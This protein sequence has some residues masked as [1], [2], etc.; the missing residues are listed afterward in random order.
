M[1]NITFN[2]EIKSK[3][4]EFSKMAQGKNLFTCFY[5]NLSAIF[6]IMCCA[7]AL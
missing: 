4:S 2:K 3:L 6:E 5:Q 1:G 7:C